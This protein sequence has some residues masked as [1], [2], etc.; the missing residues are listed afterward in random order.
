MV[1]SI[2]SLGRR[3]FTL[4]EL[5]VVIAII[6]ILIG[7]LLPAVQKVRESAN[8][9]QCVNNLKQ[10]GI[11]LQAYHGDYNVFPVG[12]PN[13][14]NA[15]W[16]WGAA[17]LPYIEQGNLYANLQATANTFVIFVPGGGYNTGY[18]LNGS[19]GNN[20][21]DNLNGSGG[22]VNNNGGWAGTVLKTYL[23]PSDTWPTK[24]AAGFAKTNYLGN[25]GS[26][27]NVWNGNFATW[28]PPTGANMNGVLLQSNDNFSTWPVS[29]ASIT[30]GTSNT[31]I[32]S[33]AASNKLSPQFGVSSQIFPIW[34]GGNP[35][36][37]GQG[38]QANYFRNIDAKYTP[39]SK[40][41]GSGSGCNGNYLL[42]DR[43]FN[44]RHTGGINAAMVDGSVK[45]VT[46]GI[47][48]NTW[49]AAGTRNGGET[50]TLP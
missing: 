40:N 18:G 16:G 37:S 7:L 42:L 10:L 15:N 5:L 21:A 26:D 22:I 32:V 24:T 12:E 41:T 6:A 23:C 1:S 2:R 28:G 30:D 44:S 48:P 38:C 4:I 47:D 29:M 49:Q 36:F 19:G 34:G 31:V 39:N 50:L 8:K 13:D 11:A 27:T 43:A 20:N 46:D 35:N 9:T 25:I 45:F 33:E 14:D 3:G 17:I